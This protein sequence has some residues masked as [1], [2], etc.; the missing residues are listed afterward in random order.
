M[1]PLLE[2]STTYAGRPSNGVRGARPARFRPAA[3]TNRSGSSSL[4]LSSLGLSSV[5][6]S[7]LGFSSL[8]LNDRS[9]DFP[10]ELRR[11]SCRYLQ[12]LK[13]FRHAIF[14]SFRSRT[15]DLK[16]ASKYRRAPRPVSPTTLGSTTL[17]STTL[18]STTLGSTTLG[19]TTLGTTRVGP[20][21]DRDRR[22]RRWAGHGVAPSPG[23]A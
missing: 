8:D 13:G 23:W 1:F 16:P 9:E 17:G 7:S 15:L 10:A 12:G 20:A 3:R 6:P 18:G 14:A 2:L 11:V 21:H 4:G 19:S 5:G 22:R